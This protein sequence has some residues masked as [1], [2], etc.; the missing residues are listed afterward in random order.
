MMLHARPYG[1]VNHMQPVILMQLV[2]PVG[3]KVIP[4]Q[5]KVPEGLHTGIFLQ[6]IPLGPEYRLNLRKIVF[7]QVV[8][9]CLI[10]DHQKAVQILRV[11]IDLTGFVKF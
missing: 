11:C 4:S 9:L 3:I 1:Q 8:G 7:E 10:G 2:R 5:N 6:K